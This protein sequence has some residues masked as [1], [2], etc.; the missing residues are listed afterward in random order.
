MAE[1]ISRR[2]FL[3]GAGA[4]AAAGAAGLAG[5][6]PKQEGALGETGPGEN[7]AG[8]TEEAAEG[9]LGTAPEI[10]EDAIVETVETDVLVVGGGTGGL[11]AACAAREEGAETVMLEQ[12]EKN[13][14]HGVRDDLGVYNSKYQ[15]AAGAKID[16]DAMRRY[17]QL[18]SG[19]YHNAQ[20]FKIWEE[21]SGET[22]DWYAA[23]CEKAGYEAKNRLVAP[24]DEQQITHYPYG[25]M[26]ASI[27]CFIDW[28]VTD[29]EL[30]SH[31]HN[32]QFIL[33]DY[34]EEI[35]VDCRFSTPMVK[36][37]KEG[38]RVTGCIAQNADGD[39]IRV[40][41][42]KGVILCTGGYMGNEEMLYSL[43]PE[44]EDLMLFSS[45]CFPG[46]D[47][48]GIKAG[49]WAGGQLDPFHSC[50]L[51]P[52]AIIPLGM[53]FEEAKGKDMNFSD[54][55]PHPFLRVNA[56][57]ERFMNE[58]DQFD[59]LGHNLLYQ[60]EKYA[61]V[62]YD[63]DWSRKLQQMNTYNAFRYY[64]YDDGSATL[65]TEEAVI[66]EIA[67]C[68]ER[69]MT[70]KA[71]TLEDLAKALDIPADTF[72]AT[73]ERYNELCAKGH[74]DDFGKPAFRMTPVDTPP[75]YADR[76]TMDGSHTMD[77]LVVDKD[78]RVLDENNRPIEGLW[79]AG[80]C[81]GCFLG[82]T[83]LG[84]LAG[85]AAG[86]TITFGRHAGRLVAQS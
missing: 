57:G 59:A 11:F 85:I 27:C 13:A 3:A 17:L 83:Y 41:A 58:D 12:F 7:A 68:V 32:G 28:G 72:V 52:D 9:W 40:N 67:D 53:T 49:M 5:C 16:I 61:I 65:F 18:G 23:I 33:N 42:R 43:Q 60:P 50:S 35:G 14:G 69:G 76:Y 51:S 38:D 19:Y 75:Y 2:S 26:S 39:Y 56:L 82:C 25:V 80:D 8:G 46:T 66:G 30:L 24:P 47:G 86:R 81:A 77:G 21:E 44:I 63:S 1:D 71:D 6:A 79:A 29:E 73:V 54:F 64:P 55:G 31:N 10:A 70:A 15:K 34:A 4:L 22:F 62:V 37:E 45:S 74:D 48:L 20:M 36:L 84:T 78:G